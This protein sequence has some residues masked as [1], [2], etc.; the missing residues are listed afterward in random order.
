MKIILTVDSLTW[1]HGG[2][3]RSVPALAKALSIAGA[4]IELW[5]L[6]AGFA[7]V[8]N[9]LVRGF[10]SSYELANHLKTM[11]PKSTIVHDNGLW[12]PFNTLVSHT[13]LRHKIRYV[14]SARGM[15]DPRSMNQSFW[16]KAVAWHLYQRRL[17]VGASIIHA[18]SELEAIGVR[19]IGLHKRV[20]VMPNGVDIPPKTSVT[21][22]G[23]SVLF[24]SRL[25][26]QKG[27]DVLLKTWAEI[28]PTDWRLKIAGGG[29]KVYLESLRTSA[30][31]LG[32][33]QS[34]DW[35]GPLDDEKKWQAYSEA[36]FF[37]LPSFSES[38]GIVIAEALSSGLPVITTTRT[39]WL[40]LEALGCG[41]AVA[42]TIAEIGSALSAFMNL[43]VAE[44][45]A[46]GC[47]G[48]SL[49]IEKYSW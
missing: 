11:D 43:S 23:N 27:I 29:E 15:L 37:V 33:S 22:N 36:D 9:V 24:L 12:R 39:P 17:L 49:M 45:A 48:R 8:E 13:A 1:E 21:K 7:K 30:D 2:P 32:I 34:I 20:F 40:E 3:S 18:T 44:R 6:Q 42:P 16:R 26:P 38:F 41:I 14:I 10:R 35:L 28:A 31:R 46:M 5:T 4:D 25:H 19:K 47:K